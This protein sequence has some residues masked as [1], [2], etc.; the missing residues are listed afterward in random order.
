LAATSARAE[1]LSGLAAA[2]MLRAHGALLQV[3]AM[4][5]V[6]GPCLLALAQASQTNFIEILNVRL[7]ADRR[8]WRVRFY[9]G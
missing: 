6:T 1:I 7:A 8:R 4:T 9:Y 3:R 2:A 5:R